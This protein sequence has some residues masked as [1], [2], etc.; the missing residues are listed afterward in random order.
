MSSIHSSCHI[1]GN[2]IT[3]K[4]EL[5]FTIENDFEAEVLGNRLDILWNDQILTVLRKMEEDVERVRA[6]KHIRLDSSLKKVPSYHRGKPKYDKETDITL[7]EILDPDNNPIGCV[8]ET[9]VEDFLSHLN[10]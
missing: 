9:Y 2:K 6:G 1:H 3:V 7:I 8:P 10:H 4:I 5:P